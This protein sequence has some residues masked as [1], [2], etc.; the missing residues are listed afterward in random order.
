MNKKIKV[1]QINVNTAFL[2]RMLNEDK[3]NFAKRFQYARQKWNI[4]TN[5][6]NQKLEKLTIS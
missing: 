2:K 5:D 3:E 6:I 1:C 4:D